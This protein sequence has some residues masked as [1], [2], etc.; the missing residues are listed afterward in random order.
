MD[1]GRVQTRLDALVQEDR[2]EDLAG[3]RVEAEGHVGQTQHGRHAGQLGLNGPD[4]LNGLDAVL[5]ALLHARRQRQ[6]ERVEEE[7]LGRQPVTL[8][9]DVA[10][11]AGGPQ[12][13][14][15][16]AGLA[17]LVNAGADHGGAELAGEAQERV[18]PGARTVALLEVDRVEDGPAA[19]PLQRGAHHRPLGGVDHERHARLRAE[20]AGDFGHVGH[21]VGAGVVDA[22][23]NE[24][25]AF[26]D[27]V[28]R[29]ADAGVPVTVEHRLAEGLGAVGVG[30]LADGQVRRVLRERDRAVDGGGGG[31]VDG[32]AGGR[33]GAGAACHHGGQV[34]G[35][36]PAAPADDGHPELGH[37]AVQVLGQIVG[38]EV[39]VHQAVDHRR[40]A[41]IRDA[42]D[43][44]AAGPR[45]MAQ[46]L[47]HL[48]RPGGA[49]EADHV[50]LHGV[51][52]GE[53]GGDLGPGQHAPGELNGD[54]ALQR[55]VAVQRD[56]G[57]PGAV[58]RGLDR[59]HVELRLNEQQVG[60]AL[61]QPECLLLVGVTELGVGNVPERGELGAGPHG[62]GH[63]AWPLRRGELVA[64]GT[65]E[66]GGPAGQLTGA[67]GQPVLGHDDRGRAEGIGLDHV[68]AHLV[69]G[70][71]HLGH[72]VRPCLD[73]PFVAA[74]EV[75]SAEVVGAQAEQL[76]VRPHGP[77]EDDHSLAQCLQVRRGGRVEP[78]E[79]FRGG[80]VHPTRIP[81]ASRT[82]R[83]GL[84]MPPHG[85]TD[86]HQAG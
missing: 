86:L 4:A 58:D 18:E 8:D 37:E 80:G 13:P 7:V 60:A 49:V 10:D 17:L 44:D 19:E 73:Q 85:T 15:R 67:V 36:G 28:P 72:Q 5:P 66:L 68:A 57:A 61:Q 74:F 77:V 29:H 47:A 11:V 21:P 35:C 9:R 39:V 64:H 23:V 54:L 75:G 52:H 59:Q 20:P 46:R 53:R 43:R 22:D 12:L 24:V 45:K 78:T 16:R 41:R 14:L 6:G 84:S 33:C 65:G 2:V 50:D 25:G 55:H 38:R 30:P 56:H 83:M 42:G 27:L 82:P 81:V 76:Q 26:L 51:E 40:E 63:P 34:L 69:E 71:V 79:E 70:A 32:V 3:G 48:H 62:A 1:N 31:L